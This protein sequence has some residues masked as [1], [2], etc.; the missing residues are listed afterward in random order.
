MSITTNVDSYVTV[1]EADQ[2]VAQFYVEDSPTSIRWTALN[3]PSKEIYLRQGF[4]QIERLPFLGTKLEDNQPAQFPRHLCN[5][6][7]VE[8][9]IEVKY[10]QIEQALSLSDVERSSE[11]SYR[12]NLQREGV[13]SFSI[14][15]LS[16]SYGGADVSVATS[17]RSALTIEALAWINNWIRGS[18]PIV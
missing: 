1:V 7:N 18:F 16:E 2:Y 3:E 14:G 4:A 8:I 17:A 10:A 11:S 6:G 12:R 5:Y 13:S 9:P 15:K